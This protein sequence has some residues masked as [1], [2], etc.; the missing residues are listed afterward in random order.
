R[1]LE[2]LQESG[3]WPAALSG[4]RRNELEPLLGPLLGTP[5]TQ[6]T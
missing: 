2:A 5:A 3:E 1:Y 6:P 4:W